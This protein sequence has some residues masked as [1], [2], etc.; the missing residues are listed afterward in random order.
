MLVI[1]MYA[2]AHVAGTIPCLAQEFRIRTTVFHHQPDVDPAIVSRSVSIFHAEKV[3]DHVDGLGE[4]TVF[5]PVQKRLIILNESR[6]IKAVINFDEIKNLL[7]VARHQ[8]Q[9]Y[10][11]D[12]IKR[13]ESTGKEIAAQLKFQLDPVFDVQF[14]E[15]K[16]QLALNSQLISYHVQCVAPDQKEAVETYLRFADWMA[17]MNYVLHP[18]TL[19]PGS[20]IALNEELRTRNLIPTEVELQTR[21][22]EKL[23]LRAEH[24]IHWKLDQRDRGLIHHWETLRKNKDVKTITIH[25]YLRNQF[26]NLRK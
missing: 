20:R 22:E 26:A 2:V 4:V 11:N 18:Y 23:Y 21:L 24:K 3:Y 14:D 1:G 13:Q 19:P 16:N 15:S 12:Q 6:M 25:E 8:T 17:R 10:V 7:N 5:D 9:E